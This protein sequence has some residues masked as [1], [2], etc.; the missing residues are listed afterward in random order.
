ML[1]GG[2]AEEVFELRKRVGFLEAQ[3]TRAEASAAQLQDAASRAADRMQAQARKEQELEDR[4]AA[5]G[6]GESSRNRTVEQHGI[7]SQWIAK[8]GIAAV[9]GAAAGVNGLV[10]AT[11]K[12]IRPQRSEPQY[13][14]V[15]HD[16]L[17]SEAEAEPADVSP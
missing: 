8:A 11:N 15:E 9:L 6:L 4:L 3:L 16:A 7:A 1:P 14:S 5:V 2:G 10:K 17:R 12:C 13:S